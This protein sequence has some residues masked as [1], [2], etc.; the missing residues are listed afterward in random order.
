MTDM[1]DTGKSLEGHFD[2]ELVEA[3]GPLYSE[4]RRFFVSAKEESLEY[5]APNS[6]G[7]LADYTGSYGGRLDAVHGGGRL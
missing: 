6:W 7:R 1:T 4:N 2:E 3:I 5:V